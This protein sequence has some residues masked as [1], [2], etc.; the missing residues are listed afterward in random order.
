MGKV[1]SN[2]SPLLYL[3]RSG[4]IDWLPL[5][6]GEIWVPEAVVSEL[7]EGKSRG[8]DVPDPGS[9]TWITVRNPSHMPSAWLAVDL[10]LGEIAAISLALEHPGCLLLL[11]DA[12]ARRT[13]QAAGLNTWGT[14]RI[15]LESKKQGLTKE[16]RPYVKR[17]EEADM[18]LSDEISQRIL[19]L[20]GEK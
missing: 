5:L 8:Y 11:D 20:A 18:W 17:L 9:Y 12:L 14:L 19:N 1:I 2:T 15:L 16:I 13:A 4:A 6:F 7:Q 10:G 3:Y